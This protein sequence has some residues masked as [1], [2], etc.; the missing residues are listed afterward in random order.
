MG[1]WCASAALANVLV[2]TETKFKIVCI[3]SR[4][5]HF[6]KGLLRAYKNHGFTHKNH[7]FT[8]NHGF[9]HKN[10]GFTHKNPWFYP[11]KPWFYSQKP[12]VLPRA[13]SFSVE[14]LKESHRFVD[15]R[16]WFPAVRLGASNTSY[17]EQAL[18]TGEGG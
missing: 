7:G 13:C 17:V 11:Q 16:R 2:M 14:L 1:D 15:R 18:S 12:M 5:G 3:K 6:F 10:H 8:Q 9:T 4:S